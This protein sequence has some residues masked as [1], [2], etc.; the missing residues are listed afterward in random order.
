MN[1]DVR[2][3]CERMGREGRGGLLPGRQRPFKGC[4]GTERVGRGLTSTLVLLALKVCWEMGRA[5]RRS[6]ELPIGLAGEFGFYPECN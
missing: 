6:E 4:K 5:D 2:D 1:G 3:E